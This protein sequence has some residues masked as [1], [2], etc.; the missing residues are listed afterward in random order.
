M[1]IQKEKMIVLL[2]PEGPD[3]ELEDSEEMN[4]LAADF[5]LG[6]M[7]RDSIVPK[8]VLYY[9]GEVGDEDDG[10]VRIFLS[11][12][13]GGKIISSEFSMTKMREKKMMMTMMMMMTIKMKKKKKAIM[14]LPEVVNMVPVVYVFL[15]SLFPNEKICSFRN[16]EVVN[17]QVL[18]VNNPNAN[19][20]RTSKQSG[21]V[22]LFFFYY[23]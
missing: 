10:A 16:L 6:H 11:G 21:N 7:L 8:A 3:V 13:A 20:S 17:I 18:V 15:R 23:H 19:N 14:P 5:E 4:L 9:T 1:L 2:V 22:F 12:E